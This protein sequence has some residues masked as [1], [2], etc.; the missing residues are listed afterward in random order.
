MGTRVSDS[1]GRERGLRC[2]ATEMRRQE[3]GPREHRGYAAAGPPFA[4]Y[5]SSEQLYATMRKPLDDAEAS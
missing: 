4:K 3:C 5:E 1:C 2:A